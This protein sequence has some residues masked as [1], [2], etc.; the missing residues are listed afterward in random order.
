MTVSTQLENKMFPPNKEIAAI[1]E[2]I[3]DIKDKVDE[4]INKEV[5]KPEEEI[6]EEKIGYC[7]WME[8]IPYR[9]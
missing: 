1:N 5:H 8:D 7:P 6:E 2:V 9:R 4:K 3:N